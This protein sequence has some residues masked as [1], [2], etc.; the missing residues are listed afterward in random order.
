MRA[1]K[2]IVKTNIYTRKNYVQLCYI[3]ILKYVKSVDC[4]HL[5]TTGEITPGICMEINGYAITLTNSKLY[6]I[7]LGLILSSYLIKANKTSSHSSWLGTM[8]PWF[9]SRFLH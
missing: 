1:P 6:K 5:A 9:E 7:L 4:G 8:W 3:V 2:Y